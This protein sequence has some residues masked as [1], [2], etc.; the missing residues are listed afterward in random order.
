MLLKCLASVLLKAATICEAKHEMLSFSLLKVAVGL[1]ISD[2]C[3]F[4]TVKCPLIP[5]PI[6]SV[7]VFLKAF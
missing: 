1:F 5:L 3:T 2:S 6:N 4:S 7:L